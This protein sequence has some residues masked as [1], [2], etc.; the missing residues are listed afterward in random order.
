M[1]ANELIRLYAQGERNFQG[2][3]LRG[4]SFQGQ[5]LEGSDFSHADIR[6]TNF[7]RA[8][9][10]NANSRKQHTPIPVKE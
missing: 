2:A 9:L 3:N 7:A 1:K 4:E 5:K 6:G 10:S 8:N